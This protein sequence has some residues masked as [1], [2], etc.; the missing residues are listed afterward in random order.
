MCFSYYIP[1]KR[2]LKTLQ[3]AIK[4]IRDIKVF[5]SSRFSYNRGLSY[6]DSIMYY[7]LH[8]Q[9]VTIL[10]VGDFVDFRTDNII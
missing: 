3:G 10:T 1:L 5:Q 2:N 7:V 4:Q 8:G 9:N 6:R